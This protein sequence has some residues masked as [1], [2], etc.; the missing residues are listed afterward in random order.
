MT[1]SEQDR[2]TLI[3]FRLEQANEAIKDV[4]LLLTHKRF[5]T[6]T[7]R[8]Y[9]GMFY[10]VMALALKYQ[11]TTSKHAQLIGWF[12]KE[13]IH[14]E[15][16]DKNFGKIISKAFTKRTKGDYDTFFDIDEDECIE[17]FEEMKAFISEIEKY[18][19]NN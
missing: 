5:R 9:Y 1:L 19:S 4:E 2:Q 12:N 6:S 17:M 8:I 16:I 10:S 11:F 13:F 15:K 3:D 18:I 14:S 7:N